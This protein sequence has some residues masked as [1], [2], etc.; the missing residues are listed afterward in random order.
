M[1]R[2]IVYG[3]LGLIIFL[4]IGALVSLGMLEPLL[5]GPGGI[6]IAILLAIGGFG[7]WLGVKVAKRRNAKEQI[8]DPTT[9]G[10]LLAETPNSL[11]WY[12]FAVGGYQL[13]AGLKFENNIITIVINLITITFGIAQ[14][15][16]AA[17]FITLIM[18]KPDFIIKFLYIQLVFSAL[19]S[20]FLFMILK[21]GGILLWALFG[22]IAITA[23][24]IRNTK[25]I[26]SNVA[27]IA[28]NSPI[29]Q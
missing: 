7:L 3:F 28:V 12:F 16:I 22:N 11:R 25:R 9:K 26:N 15:Y 24:L 2:I 21:S 14:I 1:P 10:S 5:G 6:Y 20:I 8:A 29:K 13:V 4:I 18:E 27:T 23:Y 19:A 17:K